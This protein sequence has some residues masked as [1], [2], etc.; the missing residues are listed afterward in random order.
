M[1]NF[2]LGLFGIG[3]LLFHSVTLVE[4]IPEYEE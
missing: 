1:P 4:Y 3:A 2:A